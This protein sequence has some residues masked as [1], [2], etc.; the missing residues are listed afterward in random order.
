MNALLWIVS[1]FWALSLVQTILNLVFIRTLRPAK[2]AGG[3]L[4]SVIIPARDEEQAIERTVLAFLAQTYSAF[5]VIV[6]D[7]RS[8]DGTRGILRRIA[9]E[10]SRLTVVEGE[11]P[12]PGWLGKPWA[13]HQGSLRAR[14]ELLLFVD[15]DIVYAPE[16]LGAAV[17]EMHSSRAA[18]IALFPH[19]EMHGIAENAIMP[20]LTMI[21][22]TQFPIW[23]TDRL[24][25]QRF[26]IGGGT[27]NLIRRAEYETIGGHVALSGAVID[28]VGLARH[29]RANGH[30]TSI[31]RADHLISVR[32]Y[33]GLG[34]CLR[35]FTKNAFST[36]ERSYILGLISI[37]FL[38]M[39]QLLPFAAAL[40]GNFVALGCIALILATR[41]VLFTALRY[42]LWSAVFLQPVQGALWIWIILRSAWFTGIRRK[43]TWRGRVYDSAATRFGARR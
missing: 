28:D 9:E 7:D 4:V 41:I 40:T 21:G 1:A 37:A 6:V 18:M 5:E 15:A 2:L 34:E 13:L 42:P 33:R 23:L 16:A 39:F 30:R 14:G 32:M 36:I 38:A 8:T 11:E 3:P 35:G 29:V 19:M 20:G 10:D 25:L 24:S 31:V 22:F 17:A 27:G 12:P 43:V 26:A